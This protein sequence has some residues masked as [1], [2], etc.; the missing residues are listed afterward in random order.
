MLNFPKSAF[1]SIAVATLALCGCAPNVYKAPATGDKLDASELS[2][3]KFEL[4]QGDKKITIYEKPDQCEGVRLVPIEKD[5]TFKEVK[6]KR[7][8]KVS[9]TVNS[10]LGRQHGKRLTVSNTCQITYTL[11]ATETDYHL[12]YVMYSGGI[13]NLEAQR[14]PGAKRVAEPDMEQREYIQD[15][16]SSSTAPH[17]KLPTAP[18]E[19]GI[20]KPQKT[21]EEI[22]IEQLQPKNYPM[23]VKGIV[24]SIDTPFIES[25][26]LQRQQDKIFSLSS[27]DTENKSMKKYVKVTKSPDETSIYILR[28]GIKIPHPGHTFD[29]FIEYKIS[30]NC[31]NQNKSLH[32]EYKAIDGYYYRDLPPTVSL[33][34]NQTDAQ[35]EASEMSTL[36]LLNNRAITQIDTFNSKLTL[37]ELQPILRKNNFSVTPKGN[38]LSLYR[39]KFNYNA[40]LTQKKVKTGYVITAS[41]EV[42]PQNKGAHHSDFVTPFNQIMSDIKASAQQ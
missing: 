6:V 34:G 40:E 13:C 12:K 14:L 23:L 11:N 9:F 19:T 38:R 17:C 2:T 8:E 4:P 35:M 29:T 36:S 24:F 26:D 22:A 31:R 25:E 37:A 28:S 16:K 41:I 10:V 39:A 15:S 5:E 21:A 32:C 1:H 20:G 33:D 42:N 3:I 30:A 7:G 18:E 27:E